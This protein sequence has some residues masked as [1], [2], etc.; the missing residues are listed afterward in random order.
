MELI[1]VVTCAMSL[2]TVTKLRLVSCYDDRHGHSL[3]TVGNRSI[4]ISG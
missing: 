1:F 2:L 4:I 3:R